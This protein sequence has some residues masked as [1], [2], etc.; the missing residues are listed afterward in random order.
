MYP[1]LVMRPSTIS[2]SGRL[3]RYV[4]EVANFSLHRAV[5]LALDV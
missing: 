3:L 1:V 5:V 4:V 2:A